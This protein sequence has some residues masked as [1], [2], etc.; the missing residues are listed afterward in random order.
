[1]KLEIEVA[2]C[3]NCIRKKKEEIY[4]EKNRTEKKTQSTT[5]FIF[6]SVDGFMNR[7]RRQLAAQK[8]K[9]TI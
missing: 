4:K 2:V 6:I 8:H 3:D 5:R 7:K 9:Y 1:L